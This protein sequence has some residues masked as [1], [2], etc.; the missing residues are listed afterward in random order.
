MIK[1]RLCLSILTAL[2]CTQALAADDFAGFFV[3]IKAGDNR[4]S[5]SGNFQTDSKNAVTAGGE[6]GY[7]VQW[8]SFLIG[9]SGFY[10][11]VDKSD[12]NLLTTGLT[13]NYG[14]RLG[15]ADFKLG[16]PVNKFL[17]YLK[18][19]YGRL[20][21]SGGDG[22]I[23]NFGGNDFHGGAGLEYKLAPHWGL[24]AEWTQMRVG[25]NGVKFKSNS[26]TLNLNY[27]FGSPAPAPVPVAAPAPAP[28]PEPAPA[29]TPAPAPQPQVVTKHFSLKTD[30]LFAFG[31]NALKPEGKDELDKLYDEVK[32][33][34]PKEGK[35]IVVGYT[36]RIG[37]EKYNMDLGYRRAKA[38]VDYLVTKGVPADKIDAQSKGK[39]DPVTGDTCAKIKNRKKLIECLAP[40]RRVEIDVQGVHEEVHMQENSTQ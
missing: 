40:D 3:G 39:A 36:D 25:D 28:A 31:K 6:I 37:S 35:A 23:N 18:L 30:V 34:D 9:L 24:A 15:G 4:S 12:H 13:S 2:I 32:G 29:P 5:T 1:Q 7:N 22:L 20:E 16:V 38:V 14:A 27:Y 8:D 33:L 11:Y 10:D 19:G 26:Y 21:G 17:P